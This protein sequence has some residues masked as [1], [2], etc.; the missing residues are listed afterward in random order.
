M[1][2]LQMEVTAPLLMEP[3]EQLHTARRAATPIKAHGIE[4]ALV[5]LHGRC[6]PQQCLSPLTKIE[7]LCSLNY[8]VFFCLWTLCKE[9]L[10]MFGY[11]VSH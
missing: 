5:S 8:G 4:Q 10:Q 2:P 1:L 11:H 9:Y 3:M 7:L 6:C